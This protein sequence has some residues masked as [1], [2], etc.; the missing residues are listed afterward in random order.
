MNYVKSEEEM[1]KTTDYDAFRRVLGNRKVLEE[2]VAKITNSFNRI[3][4]I[5]VPIIVNEKMEVIDGQGRLEACR[6]KLLPINFIIRPGLKIEDCISM[7]I[8]TTPWKLM[9]Y[10]EC[11]AETKNENYE[12]MYD[13][14]QYMFGQYG[15]NCIS[16]NNLCT[17]LFNTKKAP[18]TAIKDGRL[19]VTEEM[20]LQAKECLEYVFS[21][22]DYFKDNKVR[23]KSND[24]SDLITCLIF[25]YKFESVDNDKLYR[26]MCEN[27]HMM[28]KWTNVETCINEIDYIYNYNA[29]AN[30][31]NIV[32]L[33]EDLS[34]NEDKLVSNFVT[35]APKFETTKGTQ[36]EIDLDQEEDEE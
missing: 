21:I 26:V 33:Y 24:L 6:R 2:R 1:F 30:R 22:I 10:I 16:V 32:R 12:R 25:C 31:A 36:L 29:K 20:K 13:L 27:G 3:G 18:G 8:N 19:R 28:Q 23:L 5:P 35:L 11:Y 7:N 34:H 4:Y 9:D 14:F 17:A 15:K